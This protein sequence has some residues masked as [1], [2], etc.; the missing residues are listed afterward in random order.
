MKRSVS[1]VM[2]SPRRSSK[3]TA[4]R[5]SAANRSSSSLG[6]GCALPSA[7]V[8]PSTTTATLTRRTAPGSRVVSS[9]L[10]EIS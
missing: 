8:S 10:E 3:P 2:R 4:E 1:T 6:R 7:P 5:T 9:T